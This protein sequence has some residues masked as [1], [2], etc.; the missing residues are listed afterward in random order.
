[1]SLV[2]CFMMVIIILYLAYLSSKYL[3]KV[4]GRFTKSPNMTIIEQISLGPDKKIAMIQILDSYYLLGFSQNGITILDKL[5]DI[6]SIS[7]KAS[8]SLEPMPSFKQVMEKMRKHG[9]TK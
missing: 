5:G 7:L 2:F 1:M 8:E 6:D 9:E 3:G 4:S